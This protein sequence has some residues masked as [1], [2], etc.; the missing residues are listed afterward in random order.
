MIRPIYLFLLFFFFSKN[1][2][3][4][5]RNQ[6]LFPG[7]NGTHLLNLLFDN[8]KTSNVLSY[9]DARVK[10]YK[11]IY[12]VHD[13]VY[14][15]YSHHGL[16]LD[17]NYSNPIDYLSKGGSNNGI[18]CEHTFPQSKG[19][20]A[21]NARSDMHHLFP[22]R[23]AVNEARSNYP[24]SEID[25]TKTKTWYYLAEE[26]AAKPKTL[27]DEYS[28]SLSGFFEPREDHKGNVAR[29]IFYFFTMYEIQSDRAF[30]ES[31]RPTL[32]HWHMQDPVDSLEWKRTF[33]ISQYQDGKANP[34]VLDCTLPQR[35]YCEGLINCISGIEGVKFEGADN[36][37]SPN[38]ASDLIRIYLNASD[39]SITQFRITS[40]DGKLILAKEFSEPVAT[41]HI[42]LNISEWTSGIYI[43]R[44]ETF[45]G[46]IATSRLIKL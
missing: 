21:G 15:V 38:P 41:G 44:W 16:Y 29:A 45:G 10:L 19:A 6:I 40:M 25:D 14:C 5:Y 27:V 39:F 43:V 26:L 23:A 18:N 33:M 22:A 37:I 9:T 28:E 7:E 42:D 12:N 13:T 32:C 2:I 20:D 36:L 4:Q 35:C 34:F 30:F 3:G 46:K 24:Y 1:C 17:P 11:E 8:Y 31:M